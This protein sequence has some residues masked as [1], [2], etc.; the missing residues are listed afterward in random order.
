[1]NPRNLVIVGLLLAGLVSLLF[2]AVPAGPGDFPVEEESSSYSANSKERRSSNGGSAKNSSRSGTGSNSGRNSTDESSRTV[3]AGGSALGDSGGRR[4]SGGAGQGSGNRRNGDSASD[5]ATGGQGSSSNENSSRG[6]R[7]GRGVPP[8]FDRD[9]STSGS[10]SQGSVRVSGTIWAENQPQPLSGSSGSLI[11]GINGR[12]KTVNVSNGAFVFDADSDAMIRFFSAMIDSKEARVVAPNM[13]I[14]AKMASSVKVFIR[15]D[16]LATLN[17]ISAETGESLNNVE[18]VRL[19][20]FHRSTLEHPGWPMATDYVISE[21]TGPVSLDGRLGMIGSAVVIHARAAGHEWKRITVDLIEGG[22]R[23]VLL[24]PSGS[25]LLDVSGDTE[26]QDIKLRLRAPESFGPPFMEIP[27]AGGMNRLIEGVMPGVWVATLES[28]HWNL[29]PTIYEEI[30]FEVSLGGET[31]LTLEV[32]SDDED[33]AD[34]GGTVFIPDGWYLD[35]FSLRIRPTGAGSDPLND[36]VVVQAIDMDA[37]SIPGGDLFVWGP[38]KVKIGSYGVLV[39]PVGYG[40]LFEVTEEGFYDAHIELPYPVDIQVTTVLQG[41][42][43]QLASPGLVRWAP[44]RPAGVPGAGAVPVPAT[45]EGVFDFQVPVG[46]VILSVSDQ[47]YVPKHQQVTVNEDGANQFEIELEPAMGMIL[48]L[49]EDGTSIP[50]DL[51]WHPVVNSDGHEGKVLT[52]GR[53]GSGYRVLV[54]EP[55]E[56]T[57]TLPYMDGFYPVDPFNIYCQ[58]ES[59][60]ETLIPLEAE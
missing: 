20:D 2:I 4:A 43:G 46:N 54:S 33:R 3:E 36:T 51:T 31:T 17:L 49:D 52:R 9:D 8:S 1:M 12:S 39:L 15:Y 44:S 56:Y 18:V 41:G 47:A 34:L 29:N 24:R 32:P 21:Q 57:I 26:R 48:L 28:G 7:N 27:V 38:V 53:T 30:T 19:Q 25:V 37:E 13:P 5:S 23:E 14:I 22:E 11:V 59:I 16:A 6:S 60:L 50:W 10:E 40:D 42:G 45:S 58:P 35:D 55:G